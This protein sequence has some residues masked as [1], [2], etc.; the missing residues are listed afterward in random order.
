IAQIYLSP[1][2]CDTGNPKLVRA[3]LGAVYHVAFQTVTHEELLAMKHEMRYLDMDG[4]QKLGD[5]QVATAPCIYVV[6]SEAHGVS[7]KLKGQI[8]KSVSIEMVPGMESLNVA[9]AA[10]ILCYQLYRTSGV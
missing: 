3:S 1:Q 6:G 4:T 7:P 2:C 5:L 8:G 10:G 9:V